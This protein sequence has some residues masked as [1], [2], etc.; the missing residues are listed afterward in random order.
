MPCPCC[1]PCRGSCA[2]GA[3]CATGCRCYGG[4]CVKQCSGPCLGNADC[5]TG[6]ICVNGQCV[7]DTRARCCEVGGQCVPVAEGTPCESTPVLVGVFAGTVTVTWCGLSIT[8]GLGQVPQQPNFSIGTSGPDGFEKACGTAN[9]F[10]TDFPATYKNETKYLNILKYQGT[11][12]PCAS[13][14]FA[15][16]TSLIGE[17]I[18]NDGTRDISLGSSGSDQKNYGFRK[19]VCGQTSLTLLSSDVDITCGGNAHKHCNEFPVVTIN[20]A[21]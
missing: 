18:I 5:D 4:Q 13:I 10:G 17:L 16:N 2:S 14:S 21:P 8:F 20:E 9:W 19:S 11:A 3:N 1:N 6:C 7:S 15:I 12:D